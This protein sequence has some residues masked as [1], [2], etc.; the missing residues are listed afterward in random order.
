MVDQGW[1]LTPEA[2]EPFWAKRK[3]QVTRYRVRKPLMTSEARRNYERVKLGRIST[4]FILTPGELNACRRLFER[5]AAAAEEKKAESQIS[6]ELSQIVNTLRDA[7]PSAPEDEPAEQ[8]TTPRDDDAAAKAYEE[9]MKWEE[10]ERSAARHN[11]KL[12]KEMQKDL[13]EGVIWEQPG[14]GQEFV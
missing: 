9:A 10:Y 11:R 14:D 7:A 4:D 6:A 3:I 8:V 12:Y 13:L 1:Y 5:P 2:H